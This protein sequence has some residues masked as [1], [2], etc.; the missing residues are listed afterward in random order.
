[1]RPRTPNHFETVKRLVRARRRAF[2]T[3]GESNAVWPD[4]KQDTG[5]DR[6]DSKDTHKPR[7]NKK[8]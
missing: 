2:Q 4:I 6:G 8:E 1:M 5:H 3:R 7:T